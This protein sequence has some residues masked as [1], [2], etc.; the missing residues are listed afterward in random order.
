MTA[1]LRRYFHIESN[2][3]A[4]SHIAYGSVTA[5]GESERNTI[6]LRQEAFRAFGGAGL[7]CGTTG[8][9]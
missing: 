8:S 5:F 1:R 7:G 2:T 9:P 3:E 4:N 6:S